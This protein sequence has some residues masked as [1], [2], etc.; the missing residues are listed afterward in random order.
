VTTTKNEY[1]DVGNTDIMAASCGWYSLNSME[2]CWLTS[3]VSVGFVYTV[4]GSLEVANLVS[5]CEKQEMLS[6]PMW[7]PPHRIL[8]GIVPVVMQG[9]SKIPLQP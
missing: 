4:C 8:P 2:D 9:A 5:S 1:A 6:G 3:F 7:K